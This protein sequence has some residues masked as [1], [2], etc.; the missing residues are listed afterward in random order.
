L[1][2]V[3]AYCLERGNQVDP[4]RWFD[5]YTSNGWCVGRNGM[6]DWRAAVRT[7]ERNGFHA[8]RA[9]TNGRPAFSRGRGQ[10]HPDDVR[11]GEQYGV[12]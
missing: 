10:V 12:F 2:Q 6:R 8:S 7:W 9:A 11:R 5:Y 1:E 3:A 4:Q